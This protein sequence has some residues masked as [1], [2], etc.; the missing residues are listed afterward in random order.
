MTTS[1]VLDVAGRRRSSATLPGYHAGPTSG[2][3]WSSAG[4]RVELRRLAAQAGVRRR[5]APHQLRHATRSSLPERASAE[6]HPTPTRPREP[7]DDV[8]L[9]AGHRPGRDHRHCPH[10]T[11]PNDVHHHRAALLRRKYI[12]RAGAQAPPSGRSAIAP[13]TKNSAPT[14]ALTSNA[15]RPNHYSRRGGRGL[16]PWRRS[17][18]KVVGASPADSPVRHRRQVDRALMA[19]GSSSVDGP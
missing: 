4:V 15:P 17:G 8:G 1:A 13:A 9:P 3:P 14:T 10:K 2:R 6:H 18:S 19:R 11:R 7:R 16:S 5:F 12:G